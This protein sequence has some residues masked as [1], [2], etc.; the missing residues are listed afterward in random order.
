MLASGSHNIACTTTVKWKHCQIEQ[1]SIEFLEINPELLWL[2]AL[3]LC[4]WFKKLA[5]PTQ[6]IRCKTTN[7]D[8]VARVFL[9]LSQVTCIC[10][11]ISLVHCVVLVLVL[12]ALVLVLQHLIKNRS[13]IPTSLN[14]I[15]II[16][17]E[18]YS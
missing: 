13:N 15:Y 9:H 11:E 14:S 16:N 12:I 10:F 2:M 7:R 6:P 1:F 18:N 17:T 3:L 5:P 8:L 4:D